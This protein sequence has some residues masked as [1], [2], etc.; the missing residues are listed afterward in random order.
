MFGL[1]AAAAE[2]GAGAS[3]RSNVSQA[4]LK[5]SAI[6]DLEA[7]ITQLQQLLR[8]LHAERDASDAELERARARVVELEREASLGVAA[9]AELGALAEQRDALRDALVAAE[10]ERD[11]AVA[12]GESLRGRAQQLLEHS[13]E[14][15][16]LMRTQTA[17]PFS[18]LTRLESSMS[19]L[20]PDGPRGDGAKA[21]VPHA[22]HEIGAGTELA[23][24]AKLT[25]RDQALAR[26][27]AELALAR[28]E[29]LLAAQPEDG[30]GAPLD[31]A[32]GDG[33]N[34]AAGGALREAA[35][36]P[37]ALE[38]RHSN[39]SDSATG[40]DADED[41]E[42][43][44]G[45][46][47]GEASPQLFAR[48]SMAETKSETRLLKLR[49]QA[50]RALSD[51]RLAEE[52]ARML[53]LRLQELHSDLTELGSTLQTTS[54]RLLAVEAASAELRRRALGAEL[55][56][57]VYLHGFLGLIGQSKRAPGGAAADGGEPG[58][59]RAPVEEAAGKRGQA[60]R[61]VGSGAT[62][63]PSEG[64]ASE[65]AADPLL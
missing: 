12:D 53:R 55:L 39:T 62:C 13:E 10:R 60:W 17:V 47:E 4:E 32:G 61:G 11:A 5:L 18:L 65:E 1:G 49:Q 2:R 27:Q 9:R 24:L 30:A 23:L 14:Q 29:C 33:G 44:E 45:H 34:G 43:E 6:S 36:V 50:A 58:L 26:L 15:E 48:A 42:C 21:G 37:Y 46:E 35:A 57:E 28:G 52:N 8:G 51:K 54:S 25:A 31:A 38:S 3:R 19:D 22:R 64:D 59:A 40:V 16:Q 20:A 63:G 7:H 41:G 56:G